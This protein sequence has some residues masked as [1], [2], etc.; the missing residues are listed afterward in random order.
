[1][2]N[3][4]S[5]EAVSLMTHIVNASDTLSQEEFQS[6]VQFVAHSLGSDLEDED[7]QELAKLCR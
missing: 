7:I 6:A 1:M 3:G 5:K 2:H 4:L